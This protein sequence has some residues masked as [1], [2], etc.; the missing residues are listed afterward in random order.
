MPRAP[1]GDRVPAP[2]RAASPRRC[3]RARPAAA[4]AAPGG[5]DRRGCP[6]PASGCASRGRAAPWPDRDARRP[7]RAAPSH[8]CRRPP[9]SSRTPTHAEACDLRG[10]SERSSERERTALASATR[11]SR[12]SACSAAASACW[13]LASAA[14]LTRRSASRS[15]SRRPMRRGV[16]KIRMPESTRATMP[17]PASA[18]TNSRYRSSCAPRARARN[19][20]ASASSAV[21]VCRNASNCCLPSWTRACASSRPAS[22]DRTR[23]I[24]ASK[25][26]SSV[27]IRSR[28]SAR[29][30]TIA[31]SAAAS[32]AIAARSVSAAAR[33]VSYGASASSSP[34]MVNP[35]TPVS[36]FTIWSA[37]SVVASRNRSARL[38]SPPSSPCFSS[39]EMPRPAMIVRRISSVTP[40]SAKTTSRSSRARRERRSRGPCME[41]SYGQSSGTP[42]HTVEES[43]ICR[44]F[45]GL[46]TG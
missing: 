27:A 5:S 24:C 8:R 21:A 17:R 30:A 9:R 7:P 12:R 38:T 19:R 20:S 23:A 34:L 31:G 32:R 22:P 37:R 18:S 33:P 43:G 28:A 15:R 10:V 1:R 14:S 39:R 46:P 41:R 3:G 45:T 16:T 40:A 42:F 26:R 25:N 6:P 35:R 29:S 13:A 11:A 2:R 36:W 44:T 4:S